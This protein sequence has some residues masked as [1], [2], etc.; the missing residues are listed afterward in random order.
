MSK[1][2]SSSSPSYRSKTAT[3]LPLSVTTTGPRLVAFTYP[4][5]SAATSLCEATFT[6]APPHRRRTAGCLLSR[7]W[8]GFGP[9]GVLH[10]SRRA[11][12][13]SCQDRSEFPRSHQTALV[14]EAACD[15]A[16]LC[17][18]RTATALRF[19]HESASEFR[20][21]RTQVLLGRRIVANVVRLLACHTP[22]VEGRRETVKPS[23][24]RNSISV[25]PCGCW[26]VHRIGRVQCD[27]F[28]VVDAQVPADP[29]QGSC[30]RSNPGLWSSTLSALFSGKNTYRP[31]SRR[32]GKVNTQAAHS[33]LKVA[34]AIPTQVCAR[35]FGGFILH[36]GATLY[37]RH[38]SWPHPS[39]AHPP[40]SP[41]A[42]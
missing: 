10:Q 12:E 14:V 31:M 17:P 5:K 30:L 36:Q 6:I 32:G 9:L 21:D 19:P 20:L 34:C 2:S 37:L 16:S 27:P 24:R 18:A 26:A 23:W 28:R 39:S 35:N 4:A 8:P 29:T 3:G 1:R 11:R 41:A 33:D 40:S 38:P 42:P 7:R 22:I 25:W 15:C 13:S